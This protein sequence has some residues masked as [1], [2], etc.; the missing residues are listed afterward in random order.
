MDIIFQQGL[1]VLQLYQYIKPSILS[2]SSKEPK[3]KLDKTQECFH[4]AHQAYATEKTKCSP[5]NLTS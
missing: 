3:Y 4:K 5:C 2:S 1:E